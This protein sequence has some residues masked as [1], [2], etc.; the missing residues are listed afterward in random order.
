MSGVSEDLF[1]SISQA[2]ELGDSGQDITEENKA[3]SAKDEKAIR[4]EAFYDD[5]DDSNSE[6]AQEDVDDDDESESDDSD[7]ELEDGPSQN[8]DDEPA[9][10]SVSIKNK[11]EKKKSPSY[12]QSQL[13][14]YNE[15]SVSSS[16]ASSSSSSRQNRPRGNTQAIQ[17][18][19]DGSYLS[20]YDDGNNPNNDRNR[21]KRS[22]ASMS[23]GSY[24][25]EVEEAMEMGLGEEKEEDEYES[26][27][28]IDND[29]TQA[30]KRE[31]QHEAKVLREN[32]P[33]LAGKYPEAY[34]DSFQ[35]ASFVD[36]T[37]S[38]E[39]TFPVIKMMFHF[40]SKAEETS[41][42]VSWCMQI[43]DFYNL[44]IRPVSSIGN[45][46]WPVQKIWEYF[47]IICPSIKHNLEYELRC[48]NK[49]F[50]T[51]SNCVLKRNKKTRKVDQLDIKCLNL[52]FKVMEHRNKLFREVF[53]IR[54]SQSSSSSDGSAGPMGSS[55]S[56]SGATAPK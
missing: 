46:C 34:D 26:V 29:F 38:Q 7:F 31:K 56:S 30:I 37:K 18:M 49:L 28:I 11:K 12:R 22:R 10:S 3:T 32:K 19:L 6:G 43:Q 8:D 2:F 47:H 39:A 4:S 55:S 24:L 51:I 42:I 45:K 36:E 25:D 48:M 5:S 33:N 21:L 1:A 41:D 44:H 52:Q 9:P 14:E 23:G 40:A 15:E 54:F 16:S 35:F 27:P 53:N 17:Q 13:D 20:E 50:D